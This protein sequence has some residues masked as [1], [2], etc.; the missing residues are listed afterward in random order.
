MSTYGDNAA[1]IF[2]RSSL[3]KSI[4]GYNHQNGEPVESSVIEA[5]IALVSSKVADL[6]LEWSYVR[7]SNPIDDSLNPIPRTDGVTDSMEVAVY[8]P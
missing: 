2:V 1:Y 6:G 8:K 3:E 4:E 5:Q 7:A